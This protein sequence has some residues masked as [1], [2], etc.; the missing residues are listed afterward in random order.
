[1]TL[2]SNKEKARRRMDQGRKNEE[3]LAEDRHEIERGLQFAHVM[4][5]VSQDQGNEA[6]AY[7]QALA[8]LLVEK[9]ILTHEELETNMPKGR[10]L[11]LTAPP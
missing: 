10:R 6:V 3:E 4:M 2:V 11:M 5:M 9:G 8:D 7:V 1:M